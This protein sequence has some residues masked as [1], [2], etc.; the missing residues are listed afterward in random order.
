MSRY[1]EKSQKVSIY[2]DNLDEN[3]YLTK[4]RFKSLDFKNLD[5]DK[6]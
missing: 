2:L 1:F 5:R 3:L 4:S 6:K